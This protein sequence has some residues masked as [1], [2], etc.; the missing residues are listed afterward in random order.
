MDIFQR[1]NAILPRSGYLIIPEY[2]R[3]FINFRIYDWRYYQGHD[4][5]YRKFIRALLEA[6]L[7]PFKEWEKLSSSSSP[8]PDPH[9]AAIQ[10]V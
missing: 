2:M 6:T 10:K 7:T 1:F 4:I 3:Y 9:N 8:D 5:S